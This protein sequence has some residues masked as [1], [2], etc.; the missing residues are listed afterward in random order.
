M[1]FRNAGGAGP[2]YSSLEVD[3]GVGPGT[4][5]TFVH[6]GGQDV[7]LSAAQRQRLLELLAEG[8]V[9]IETPPVP[10]ICPQCGTVVEEVL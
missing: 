1:L 3:A 8:A 10:N 2:G 6:N 5:V 4:G 9:N 7:V